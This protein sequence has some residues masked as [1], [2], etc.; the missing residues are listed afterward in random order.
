MG[1]PHTRHTTELVAVFHDPHEA[2]QALDELAHLD[3]VDPHHA[4][5]LHVA[6]GQGRDEVVPDA[7]RA[8][9]RAL[10]LGVAVMVPVCALGT[11][12]LLAAATTGAAVDDRA[13]LVLSGLPAGAV[14][15]LLFGGL[16]GIMTSSR[17]LARAEAFES[18]T[19][20]AD[21]TVLHTEFSEPAVD[22]GFDRFEERVRQ[23]ITGHHGSLVRL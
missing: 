20:E 10:A 15:G 7:D 1:R 3:R 13:A 21:D 12:A 19:V 16:V 2:V 5:H 14:L 18:I 22:L 4:H 8:L 9:G 23:I 6:A 11:A 17:T